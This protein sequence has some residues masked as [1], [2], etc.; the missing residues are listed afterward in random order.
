MAKK[1]KG[2]RP[3][4]LIQVSLQIGFRDD[5]KPDRKYFYGHSRAEA[6][7]KRDAYKQRIGSSFSPN[8]TVKEWVS[9]FLET[10]RTGVD[11]AYI[12]Q[13][14]VPYN[15]LVDAIGRRRMIDIRESDLQT[16]L[17]AVSGNNNANRNTLKGP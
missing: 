7:R 5:G 13:D 2:E 12:Q 1:R 4:G 6:E 11:P 17:N 8:I 15:R 3:D 9:V 14:N 10:Y 16:A